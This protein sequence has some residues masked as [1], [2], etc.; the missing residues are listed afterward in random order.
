MRA[1]QA[2]IILFAGLAT[3]WACANARAQVP[4]VT[5]LV[6][7]YSNLESRLSGAITRQDKAEIDALVSGEFQVI[8][9]NPANE[10][11]PRS[12]WIARSFKERYDQASIQRMAVHDFGAIRVVSFLAKHSQGK[13]QQN[14][15]M[16]IDV[17]KGLD[18]K[19]VLMTR[20]EGRGH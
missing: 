9:A 20:F 3:G 17:W 16:V 8:N 10:Q 19:S 11:I 4:V 14:E 13:N 6:A 1:F 18:E 15:V 12:E 5:R 7:I 2:V